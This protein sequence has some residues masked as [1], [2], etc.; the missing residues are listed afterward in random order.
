MQNNAFFDP[1]SKRMRRI[2]AYYRKHAGNAP[3]PPEEPEA[4]NWVYKITN[5]EALPFD[6]LKPYFRASHVDDAIKMG[7]YWACASCPA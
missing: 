7:I 5:Y 1:L 3:K 6:R 4:G 2:I